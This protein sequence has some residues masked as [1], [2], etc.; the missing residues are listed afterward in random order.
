MPL[1]GVFFDI[2]YMDKYLNFEV[3]S[4][5]F[6]DMKGIVKSIHDND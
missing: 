5:R 6:P 1:E 2:E 3:D 4:K